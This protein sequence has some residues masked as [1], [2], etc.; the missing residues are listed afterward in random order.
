MTQT[1]ALT[2]GT[3]KKTKQNRTNAD[4]KLLVLIKTYVA[5]ID[6]NY[7]EACSHKN[8][9]KSLHR[10]TQTHTRTY[11]DAHTHKHT[12][13]RTHKQTQ[14]LTHASRKVD[15][16]QF[17]QECRSLIGGAS[18]GRAIPQCW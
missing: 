2:K 14:T 5:D 7:S 13:R 1:K 12:E 9:N 6:T 4:N 18:Q 8:I 16:D 15:R 3:N 10:Y 17:I 11:E